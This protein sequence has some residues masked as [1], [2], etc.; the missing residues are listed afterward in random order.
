MKKFSRLFA[1][2]IVSLF[3][4]L[5]MQAQYSFTAANVEAQ[6]GETVALAISMNNGDV[7]VTSFQFDLYLPEGVTVE[8]DEYDEPIAELSSRKADHI[9]TAAKQKDGAYRF[10]AYSN[11]NR[12]FSGTDGVILTTN[13]ILNAVPGEYDVK[14][15]NGYITQSGT[16]DEFA[17]TET[18]SK[19]KEVLEIVPVESIS[20]EQSSYSLKVN[21]AQTLTVNF[22]PED[23]TYKTLTWTSSA[24]GVATVSEAGLVTGVTVGTAT[25]TATSH[26]GK[27]A[28]CQVTVNPVLAESI[29]LNKTSLELPLGG[30]ETLVATVLPENTTDKTVTWTSSNEAV[31]TVDNTG[32]VTAV[33]TGAATITATCGNVSATCTVAVNPVHAKSVTLNKTSLELPLGGTETLVATVLPENTTDKTVTWTSSNNA[34]AT[35]DNT[36]NVTAVGT[37]TST[38]TATCGNVSATCSVTVNPVHAKSVTLNKTSLELPLGGTEALVATVLPEN[39]TDKTVTWTSSNEAVATVDNSGNVTAVGTGTATI[40]ATCGSVSATCTVTSSKLDEFSEVNADGVTIYYRVTS[41]TVPYTV[42][43]TYKDTNFNSYSGNVNIPNSVTKAGVTFSVTAIG[44]NA[45]MSST[46]LTSVTI[47]NSVTYIAAN[48]FSGCSGLTSVTIPN[49]VTSIGDYA[50]YWCSGLTS[51]TIPNSVTSIGKIAFY[52]CKNLTTLDYNATNCTIPVPMATN[53]NVFE[54]CSSLTTLNIGKNVQTI[55]AY[56]FYGC[57]GLVSVTIPEGVTSI[58]SS[59]FKGCTG[60]T[61]VT[62]GESV[63]S[64]GSSAFSKC[65][66]LTTVNYNATNCNE[67]GGS[68]VFEG[69][70]SL[71]TLNIGEN[72]QTIPERVFYGCTGLVSVT[73]PEGV[74]SIGDCA[75]EGCTGLIMVNYNATNCTKTGGSSVFEGCSSLTTLNI[76]KNVQTIP[77]YIFYGYTG[78]TSVDIPKSVTS[79]GKY[80]FKDCSG[81][82]TVNFNATNCTKMGDYYSPAFSGC[83]NLTTLNIGENVQTIPQNAFVGCSSLTTVNYNA[84]ICTFQP[85]VAAFQGCSNFKTLN[86]GENVQTIPAYAF[87]GCTGLTSVDIPKSVISIGK[88]AFNNCSGLTSVNIPETITSIE[89]RTFN[90]CSSLTSINIPSSVTLIGNYSFYGC[91]SLTSVTIL[92]KVTSIG[93]FAFKGCSGLMS[94]TIGES[95]TSIGGGAFYECTNLAT[96]TNYSA[97]DIVKGATTHGYVAYYAKEVINIAESITLNK[98]NLNLKLGETEVLVATVLPKK[99][100]YIIEWSSSD[101]AVAT[102]DATGKITTIAL[103]N[104]TITATC[105][106]VSAHCAV[107]VNPIPAESITLNKTSLT[108]KPGAS[109]TL[110][111]TV[112]PE[113][114]TDKT[115]TWTSSDASVATVDN[116]GKVI[117]VA[118]GSATITAACGSVSATCVVTVA[119]P[120]ESV[121]LNKTSLT[122]KAGTTGNLTATVKPDN[123]TDKT[124]M[125]TSSDEA[126]A[127]V[128]NAGKITAVS[129]GTATITAT[130]GTVSATCAVTVEYSDATDIIVTPGSG[131]DDIFENGL[132]LKDGESK[133]IDLT[134]VPATASPEFVWTSSDDSVVKIDENGNIT[135]VGVGTATVTV[136]SGSFSKTFT[137]T[138]DPVP[139]ESVTLSKT[140]VT[141]KVGVSETLVATVLP[142]NATDKTVTW[143][144]SDEEVAT[145]DN[146]GK[147]TAISLGTTTITATCGNVSA[148][149]VVTVDPILAESVTLNKYIFGLNVGD[150]E[151][152]VATVKPDNTTDKKVVWT[153]DNEDIATVDQNGCV[154][155]VGVGN[156]EI[157]ATCGNAYTSCSVFVNRVWPKSITLNKTSLELLLGETETLTATVLPENTTDKTVTWTSSD[158]GVAT[159]DENGRVTAVGD[160]NA[161]ITATCGYV[162]ATCDVTVIVLAESV[163]LSAYDVELLVG[164]TWGLV[165]TVMPKNTTDKTVT[166]ISSDYS[167]V[168]VDEYYGSCMLTAVGGGNA[169]ITATCGSVSATCKVTVIVPAESVLLS[170]SDVEMLVGD[171]EM[172]VATVLPEN[173]TD[174]TVTWESSDASVVTIDNGGY[175]TAVGAGNAVV[176]AV[177][178]NAYAA[179]KVAVSKR[180]Q[181][182]VWEQSFDDIR[183]GESIFLEAF[184]TSGLEVRYE[185]VEGGELVSLVDNI[186]TVDAEGIVRIVALQDGND[187]YEAAEPVEKV[188]DIIS[189]IENIKADG[190]GRYIVWNMQGTK[191]LDTENAKDI[192]YL[193]EGFYIINGTK[194]L[195]K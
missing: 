17:C 155:G 49:S 191:V 51:V 137:V 177:C 173:T 6:K 167:V 44:K 78:L 188:I 161:T 123:A 85:G 63:S 46:G 146:A 72:V 178:G 20:F 73:I 169:T 140:S 48:A 116:T 77:A 65:T 112:L 162:S 54:G 45:F 129:K 138:V 122:L 124:V 38:I 152:L 105:G 67:T 15:K 60:L 1:F 52:C 64:I 157:R 108:L 185:I 24:P 80:A 151:T 55:P 33:G 109:E 101:E 23:A 175:L 94:V 171:T 160:G 117:A 3:G 143:T 36:G 71:T 113:N 12:V 8:L 89:E 128:D 19:L 189:G 119:I 87:S 154:T 11:K 149:C 22:L 104:A 139:A 106:P 118:E 159:V 86:I 50:F 53:M 103:G 43:V 28:Q 120:A 133:K 174:K 144:S 32:N 96:V 39:T 134:V 194:V 180:P 40:T 35:V 82:T 183:T 88:N 190:N 90:G 158:P 31:A 91:T 75:F 92:D 57:S 95:V 170:A 182:I 34:V 132:T 62:I 130:C 69:C 150:S 111:A 110:V 179:C 107:T 148:N 81:L 164:D 131:L 165:A 66:G 16:F 127:T 70:P 184:T 186:L 25:I 74:T 76:G 99:S 193:P 18:T 163:L 114:T 68:S 83:T 172:L 156:T 4:T 58:G 10:V 30:T 5:C 121:T 136:S 2:V 59:A 102:V 13:I 100:S 142:D 79:I 29:T 181:E 168:T 97:L 192:R 98:T 93:E 153:S 27:T 42:E 37:G 9:V 7:T 125:W 61:F 195:V 126:V 115:V 141:L 84:T 56:I 187:E 47:P 147:I 21:E 41:S 145:V 135:A 14:I 166:W 26:N 176:T